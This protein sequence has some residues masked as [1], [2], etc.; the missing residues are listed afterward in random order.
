MSFHNCEAPKSS[1]MPLIYWIIYRI[2]MGL[3]PGSL[4]R[5]LFKTPQPPKAEN[6]TSPFR[7]HLRCGV[8]ILKWPIQKWGKKEPLCPTLQI[9][10]CSLIPE[11]SSS[12]LFGIYDSCITGAHDFLRIWGNNSKQFRPISTFVPEDPF[13]PKY[14]TFPQAC[15]V[16]SGTIFVW[17]TSDR[18]QLG[19]VSSGSSMSLW[20]Q[21]ILWIHSLFISKTKTA[22]RKAKVPLCLLHGIL[23]TWPK[24]GISLF[25]PAQD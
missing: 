18:Q 21:L 14:P 19:K 23:W 5:L 1:S 17:T 2:C 7:D 25:F 22:L 11:T 9:P 20:L 4:K 15:S 13:F 10:D 8:C 3:L 16:F 12:A 24:L 6:P